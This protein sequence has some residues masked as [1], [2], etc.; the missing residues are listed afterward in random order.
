[1]E[2][3]RQLV[4]IEVTDMDEF[5]RLCPNLHIVPS[6]PYAEEGSS[7]DESDIVSDNITTCICD[8]PP[9]KVDVLKNKYTE[10]FLCITHTPYTF[11]LVQ[12]LFHSI[13]TRVDIS[14]QR[15]WEYRHTLMKNVNNIHLLLRISG[16]CLQSVEHQ[17]WEIL[18]WCLLRPTVDTCEIVLCESFT[19]KCGH[20]R[21]L[22]EFLQTKFHRLCVS[23]D[24]KD[25]C[26]PFWAKVLPL[27]VINTEQYAVDPLD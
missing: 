17:T 27:N 3:K 1:M 20:G 26:V 15:F 9:L 25:N 5:T 4:V 23:P 8:L 13:K 14:T 24:I 16:Y 7:D 22:V 18:S 11:D 21:K 10:Q 12:L 19:P 2:S 6:I